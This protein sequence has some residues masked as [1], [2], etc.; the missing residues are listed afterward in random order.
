MESIPVKR[1]GRDMAGVRQ[2]LSRL[3]AGKWLGIFPE[4]GINKTPEA[5]LNDFNTGAAFISLKSGVPIYPVFIENAPRAK[6]MAGSFF[7][8]T[9]VCIHYGEPIDLAAKFGDQKLNTETL[10][11]ATQFIRESIERIPLSTSADPAC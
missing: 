7:V 1:A 5:G 2:A 8:R 4:G 6:T 10:T 9:K 3:K 11:A